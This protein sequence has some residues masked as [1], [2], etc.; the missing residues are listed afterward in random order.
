MALQLHLTPPPRVLQ[1]MDRHLTPPPGVRLARHLTPP[2]RVFLTLQLLPRHWTPPPRVL[3]L[4]CSPRHRRAILLSCSLQQQARE[5]P[6]T[7]NAAQAGVLPDIQELQLTTY[8]DNVT[9]L[10]IESDF[11]T[12]QNTD[13]K[14]MLALL[15][16]NFS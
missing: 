15:P 8:G 4:S 16:A 10:A 2:P 11:D 1:L 12:C 3:L 14:G 5:G 7:F 6:P 13:C 9:S